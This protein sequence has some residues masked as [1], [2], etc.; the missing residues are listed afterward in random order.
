[1]PYIE[2]EQYR[3]DAF[4]KDMEE[5]VPT[6]TPSSSFI[7]T[8]NSGFSDICKLD[9]RTESS[10]CLPFL[11][12]IHVTKEGNQLAGALLLAVL[13]PV[14]G[15]EEELWI[16]KKLCCNLDMEE[17]LVYVWR[18]FLEN[19]APDLLQVSEEDDE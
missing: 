13:N 14:T 18:V 6:H 19:N 12:L 3:I 17:G 16:P 15:E 2:D 4:N 9:A 7:E 8:S 10:F 1:M 5:S 11:S